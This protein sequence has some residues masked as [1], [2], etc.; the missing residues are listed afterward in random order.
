MRKRAVLSTTYNCGCT[1]TCHT[2]PEARR[3]VEETGHTMSI[4]GTARLDYLPSKRDNS[5]QEVNTDG[6]PAS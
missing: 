5:N 1:F 4:I 2:W 3:H 6:V